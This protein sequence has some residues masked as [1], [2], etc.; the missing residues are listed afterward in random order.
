MGVPPFSTDL[1]NYAEASQPSLHD[2]IV[3]HVRLVQGNMSRFPN[4]KE[5]WRSTQCGVLDRSERS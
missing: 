4:Q 1:L 2:N 5:S 3:G